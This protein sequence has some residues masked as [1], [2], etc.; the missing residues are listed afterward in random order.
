MLLSHVAVAHR[1]G[2]NN[3]VDLVSTVLLTVAAADYIID[4]RHI[5]DANPVNEVLSTKLLQSFGSLGLGLKCL[6]LLGYLDSFQ[7]ECTRS[8][9]STSRTNL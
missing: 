6:G 3:L 9:L 8:L 4:A 5:Y 7:R 1:F 2:F